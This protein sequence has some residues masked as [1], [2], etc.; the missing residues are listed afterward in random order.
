MD[1]GHGN[2]AQEGEDEKGDDKGGGFFAGGLAAE[3]VEEF[4]H[5]VGGK[6]GWM[7]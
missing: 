7:A 6:T 4:A 3:G 5:G 1:E 2:G